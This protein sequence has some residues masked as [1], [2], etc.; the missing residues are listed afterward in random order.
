MTRIA[1]LTH[2]RNVDYF[3]A[4]WIKYYS[5]ICGRA[6]L[7]VMLD[8]DDWTSAVDLSGL[9]VEVLTGR[10]GLRVRDDSRLAAAHTRKLSELFQSYD[11]V[12]RGDCDE[13]V[14]IDPAAGLS[15]PE[16]LSETRAEGYVYCN[17]VDVIHDPTTEAAFDS[18]K[19]I[20]AQRRNGVLHKGYFKPNVMSRAVASSAGGHR[21]DGPVVVSAQFYMFH[22]ANFDEGVFAQRMQARVSDAKG[23]SYDSHAVTRRSVS[24]VIDTCDSPLDFDEGIARAHPTVDTR[25]QDCGLQATKVSRRN[26]RVRGKQGVFGPY[27]PTLSGH[28]VMPR[29]PNMRAKSSATVPL[30]TPSL[31]KIGPRPR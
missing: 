1:A 25:R 29:K 15:W 14:C 18:R 9:Q 26:C 23:G 3:L 31:G 20:L 21:A 17:G 27:R 30:P 28:S 16:A 22:L 4:L 7:H 19:P 5:E 11:Y 13:F 10:E 6:H 24:A 2:V 8:G 12:I